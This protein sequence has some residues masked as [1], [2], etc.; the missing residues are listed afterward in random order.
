MVF[1]DGTQYAEFYMV[2][3]KEQGHWFPCMVSGIREFGEIGEPRVILQ[4]GD[5]Y[6]ISGEKKKL[7][8]VPPKAEWQGSKS[9]RIKFARE[10]LSAKQ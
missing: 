6:R 5:N 8:F 10:P 1:A 9:F 7:K 4:K 3:D 2:D